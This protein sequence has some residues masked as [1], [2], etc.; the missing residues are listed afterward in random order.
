[1]TS[2]NSSIHENPEE[3]IELFPSKPPN[4]KGGLSAFKNKFKGAIV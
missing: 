2:V 3:C 4:E 1:M